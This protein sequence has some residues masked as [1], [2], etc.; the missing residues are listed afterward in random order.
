[1]TAGEIEGEH[2]GKKREY[3]EPAKRRR[4]R[5]YADK[6][7]WRAIPWRST[8][9][10]IVVVLKLLAARNVLHCPIV[11]TYPKINRSHVVCMR[12]THDTQQEYIHICTRTQAMYSLVYMYVDW[13]HLRRKCKDSYVYVFTTQCSLYCRRKWKFLPTSCVRV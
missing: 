7:R 3:R 5:A 10:S 11:G 4:E 13:H 6:R 9:V 2:E 8:A 1:M 12:G